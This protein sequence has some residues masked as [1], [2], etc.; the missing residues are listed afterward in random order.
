M[1]SDLANSSYRHSTEKEGGGDVRD[2]SAGKKR[3]ASL[4]GKENEAKKGKEVLAEAAPRAGVGKRDPG[5][6]QTKKEYRS[7]EKGKTLFNGGAA[8]SARGRAGRKSACGRGGQEGMKKKGR[9]LYEGR[10]APCS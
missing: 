1:I 4:H 10:A 2:G 8:L 6:S 7:D 3:S 9:F 5:S